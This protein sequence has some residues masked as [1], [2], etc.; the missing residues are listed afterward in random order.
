MRIS[1]LVILM[2]ALHA[3][4][5]D[6]V[7]APY[8]AVKPV[9]EALRDRVPSDLKNA[10]EAQW[11]MWRRKEDKAIRGR[12]EQGELDTLVNLLLFGTSFTGQP[13][14]Q[15]SNLT[16]ASRSG[17]LRAR[18]LDLL[19]SLRAPQGNERLNLMRDLLRSKG[20]DSD[21]TQNDGQAGV[22]VLE[23]V[24]RVL[25]E[26]REYARRAQD[27]KRPN[28]AHVEFDERSRLFR[29]RGISTDTSMLPG[30][31]I[32]QAL[33]ELKNHRLLHEKDL[34][35]IAVIGP[36]LDFVDWDS[37]YDY[38]PPQM[39]QPFAVY[40][41]LVRLNLTKSPAP[42]VTVFDISPWAL[43]HL[44]RAR[45]RAARG[46]SYMVQLVRDP[47]LR[48]LPATA[49]YWRALG[50]E[51]GISAAPIQP[52]LMLH[53]LE[54]RAVAIRPAVVLGC[55]PVDLN[56]VLQRLE[57]PEAERFD[58][59]IATNIFLYYDIAEQALA[60][61]NVAAMLRPGGFLLSNSRLPVLPGMAVELAGSTTVQYAEEP[62]A[63]DS[64]LWYQKR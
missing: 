13:R 48:W 12:L 56:V 10:E 47:V 28:D 62:A 46:A 21:A 55:E 4:A 27:A 38:Y 63:R 51:I 5:A 29:D 42:Q 35:R 52:P 33:R 40:D 34:Q 39:L 20:I 17:L 16:E 60:L 25:K 24:E 49:Q 1:Y 44:R 54:T 58:L 50:G 26:L 30:F 23:N 36:G 41:T 53:A 64:I 32:E 61:Q 18:L 6:R 22:F 31:G 8:A 3:S 15:I 19:R 11:D 59:V 43:G 2:L 14:I 57:I 9:L 7:F 37:G 45:E